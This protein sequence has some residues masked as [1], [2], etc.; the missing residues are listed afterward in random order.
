MST[1]LILLNHLR[2]L[3]VKVQAV[4]S[5]AVQASADALEEMNDV[6]ADKTALQAY[7]ETV[8]PVGAIYLSATASSPQQLLGGTWE[9]INHLNGKAFR[10]NLGLWPLGDS[11]FADDYDI[12]LWKRTA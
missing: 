4:V 10:Y 2:S 3:A 6:K 7:W 9:R 5:E 11:P 12:Y 8:Y 1:K